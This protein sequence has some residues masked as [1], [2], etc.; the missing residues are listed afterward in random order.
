MKHDYKPQA[1][2][3]RLALAIAIAAYFFLRELTPQQWSFFDGVD[4]I[5]HEAGHAI[6]LAFGGFIHVLG[7]TLLQ[8]LAPLSFVFYFIQ[9]RQFYSGAL[10]LFWFGQSVVNVSVYIGDA[11]AMQLPLLGGEASI[12]DWNY[13]LSSLG[14]LEHAV[15]IAKFVYVIGFA[16]L[17]LALLLSLYFS[18]YRRPETQ[19]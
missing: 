5:I 7:G 11:I 15:V 18:I 9:T 14:L 17:I 19:A 1:G 16:S 13:L 8:I 6:F 12:H 3:A 10:T 2:V 4:L